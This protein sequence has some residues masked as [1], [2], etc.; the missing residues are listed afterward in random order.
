M[1][2]VQGAQGCPVFL[3]DVCAV[4]CTFAR[5][6]NYC[7]VF[8]TIIFAGIISFS[9]VRGQTD[10]TAFEILSRWDND[11]LPTGLGSLR[12]QYSSCW[13]MA[14]N[15]HEYAIAGGTQKIIVLDVTDPYHPFEAASFRGSATTIREFKSYKNR[16]YGV[17]GGG[18]E[19]LSIIDFSKAPD[20]IKRTYYSNALFNYSH[21]ITLD[22]V[23]G[24]IYLNGGSDAPDGLTVLDVSKNPDVPEFLA[25]APLPSGSVHDSYVRH[26]TIYASSGYAGLIVYD[27]KTPRA[28]VEIARLKT[29]GYNHNSWP[30]RDGSYLYYTEEIPEGR[31]VR[32]VDLRRLNQGELEEA[33]SFLRRGL[34]LT[35]FSAPIP[36]NLYIR[37]HLLFVSQY[38]DG[39]L[40]Y[41]ISNPVS[42]VFL[43]VCDTH[44]ENTV[45]N[46]YYGNWGNYPWLPS[47]NIV[48]TDMQNGVFMVRLKKSVATKV[49]AFSQVDCIVA[50]QPFSSQLQFRLAGDVQSMYRWQLSDVNGKSFL[51]GTTAPGQQEIAV[52]VEHLCDG[53]YLL[54]L[55]DDQGHQIVRKVIKQR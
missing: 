20:T 11:T 19:G 43:G 37:D 51:A 47:G 23:S 9:S 24:R 50:P 27:F 45:Y 29:G 10:T 8:L 48:T 26:D 44:P 12:V 28:P 31:P 46:G 21:T 15:G 34:P 41:D 17:A 55:T 16:L 18:T 3:F 33:G 36:H 35:V 54:R 6:K 38:E 40:A 49:P 25:R 53:I 52:N 1:Q 13:G 7:T 2:A 22:T 42:P 30:V 5:M 4:C 39:L 32:I 14:V